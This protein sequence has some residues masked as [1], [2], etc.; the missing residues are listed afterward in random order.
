MGRAYV[1]V[2]PFAFVSNRPSTSLP[3]SK[4][5]G[6]AAA[7]FAF[8]I[9]HG[10]MSGVST[11]IL[12]SSQNCRFSSLR[13]VHRL[14]KIRRRHAGRRRHRYHPRSKGVHL[15]KIFAARAHVAGSFEIDG[16]GEAVI[17]SLPAAST[18]KT[19]EV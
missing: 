18:A 17:V 1:R 2:A 7:A 9:A 4:R 8:I 5:P 14:E 11:I 12:R 3:V 15:Q 10:A 6:E 13:L 19:F 16:E